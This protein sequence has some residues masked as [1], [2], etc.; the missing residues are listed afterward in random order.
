MQS[1][2]SSDINI[3][4]IRENYF[5]QRIK[6]NFPQISINH[7]TFEEEFQGIDY[8]IEN[9][10]IDMKWTDIFRP[11]YAVEIS[12][13]N[14]NDEL[15]MG[16]F[17]D[18]T[19]ITDNAIFVE[20]EASHKFI[21]AFMIDLQELR[22]NIFE[23]ISPQEIMQAHN[24]LKISGQYQKILTTSG[25]KLVHSPQLK[26]SPVNL[27]IKQSQYQQM[28]SYKDISY[29]FGTYQEYENYLKHQK[30]PQ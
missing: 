11:T 9:K 1:L 16:W 8:K 15:K 5:L 24:E 6:N 26:E 19:H 30:S 12:Y 25:L 20:A 18:E 21:H 17:L 3:N 7:G 4:K 27:V 2:F 10:T 29:L 13:L 23:I 14:A 22:K 28:A